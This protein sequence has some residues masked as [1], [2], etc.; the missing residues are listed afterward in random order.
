M[1]VR[2][3]QEVRRTRKIAR[4]VEREI[5][6]DRSICRE[7]FNAN[8][9]LSRFVEDVAN[10]YIREPRILLPKIRARGGC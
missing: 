6:L 1:L 2:R 3:C 10:H 8:C 5:S 4:Y 9:I 7:Q